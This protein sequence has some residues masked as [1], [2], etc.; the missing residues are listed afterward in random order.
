MTSSTSF[1]MEYSLIEVQMRLLAKKKVSKNLCRALKHPN[2]AE[3][4][5]SRSYHAVGVVNIQMAFKTYCSLIFLSSWIGGYLPEWARTILIKS[6]QSCLLVYFMSLFSMPHYIF[7]KLDRTTFN[8][9]G[10]FHKWRKIGLC[11]TSKVDKLCSMF[12]FVW[13]FRSCC[14]SCV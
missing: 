11:P 12:C 8:L 14:Y 9:C 2:T 13:I 4:I 10:T 6:I 3:R 1:V 7:Q 5:I